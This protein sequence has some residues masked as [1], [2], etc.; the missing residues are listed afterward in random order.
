MKTRSKIFL[1]LSSNYTTFFIYLGIM[2]P[3][4]ALWLKDKGLSPSEI[5]AIIAVPHLMKIVVAPLISQAADKKEEYWRPLLICTGLNLLCST[6]YFVAEDFWVLMI[7]TIAVNITL[8][9]VMPLLETVTVGQAVKHNLEYGQIRSVGSA[10]FIIAAVL[11]G[12]F[13]E[14]YDVAFVLWAIYTGMVFFTVSILFLP[15]GNKRSP[16]TPVNNN[17]PIKSLMM[18]K[19]FLWFLITVGFLQMSHGVYYAMSSIHWIEE[20]INEDTIGMLWGV[21]VIAEIGVFIFLGKLLSRNSYSTIFAVVGLIGVL[22]WTIMAVTVSV[23]LLIF[24]QLL[25]GLTYGAS[26]L[27]AIN[28]IK[29]RVPVEF[30]GSG[31]SLYTALPLGLGMAA[32]T[33]FGSLFYEHF[34]AQAY[35]AM[36]ALCLLAFFFSVLPVRRKK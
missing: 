18:N 19:G 8:P 25:H 33:Y 17:A 30:A 10:A 16:R 15:R 3:F 9:A 27:A 23:P 34:Q 2:A 13:L 7:I 29:D 31:Q 21:G 36:S 1:R 20:G 35:L 14:K 26:H 12:W 5:G 11:F 4:W 6:F 32:S 24:A 28:Y 22:R